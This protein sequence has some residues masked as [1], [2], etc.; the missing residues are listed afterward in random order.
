MLSVLAA[1]LVAGHVCGADSFAAVSAA[2][3]G[4]I[5]KQEVA[6]VVTLVAT[7]EKVRHLEAAGWADLA[8]KTPMR[9]DSICWIASM[10]KPITATAVLMMQEEG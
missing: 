10:T 5:A 2:M 9:T 7:R 6:G 8:A 1:V 4:C 3:Q